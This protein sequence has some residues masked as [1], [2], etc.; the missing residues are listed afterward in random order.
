[1]AGGMNATILLHSN[2]LPFIVFLK[3]V[4][5]SISARLS[6]IHKKRRKRESTTGIIQF[7]GQNVSKVIFK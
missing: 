2:L 7:F 3:R 1:M 6:R 5:E 4:E